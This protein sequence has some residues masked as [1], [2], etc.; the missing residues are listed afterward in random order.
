MKIDLEKL[1][2]SNFKLKNG[3]L[4][5]RVV[6]LIV[7]VEFNCKWTKQNLH[8]RSVIIDYDGNILSR[9]FNMK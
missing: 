7:P 4:N 2:L 8:F 6:Q 1:D 3:C 5:G 9:G